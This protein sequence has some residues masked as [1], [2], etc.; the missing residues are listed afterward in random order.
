MKFAL[1]LVALA[2][3]AV[4][5]V[6]CCMVPATYKGTISQSAQEAVIFHA[7]GR[8]ELILKISYKIDGNGLP[9]HFAWVITVPNEPDHY[10]IADAALFEEVFSWADQLT[11]VPSRGD[12]KGPKEDSQGLDFGKLVKVGPYEIQPVRALGLEALKG[13]NDW[14]TKNGFPAEDVDHMKYFVENKF[15]FL[16]IKISPPDGKKNVEAS[17]GIPPLHLSF[18]S[19]SIYYPLRFS[20]RQGVFDVNLYVLTRKPFDYDKSSDSLKRINFVNAADTLDNVDAKIAGFPKTLKA[21]YDK[22]AFKDTKGDWI[23]NVLR[24]HEVN[25]GNTI[26]KWERDIFF[27]TKG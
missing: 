13:L 20:S 9:E 4:P 23:L 19:E 5:A 24:T 18:K 7:D 8:E 11:T 27:S 26:A 16:A 25:K 17:G 10:E 22:T 1:A 15:T 12:S 21:V 6:P 2:L 3:I 14:L